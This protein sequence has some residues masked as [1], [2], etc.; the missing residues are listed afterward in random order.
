MVGVLVRT[1]E[2]VYY[3]GRF[4]VSERVRPGPVHPC[5]P[6]SALRGFT[7]RRLYCVIFFSEAGSSSNSA[8]SITIELIIQRHHYV[9]FN[10]RKLRVCMNAC[11][12]TRGWYA[13]TSWPALNTFRNERFPAVLNMPYCTPLTVYD[14]RAFE[15]N[16]ADCANCSWETTDWTPAVLQI[17]SG[18]Q[19]KRNV[20]DCECTA[21]KC[22]NLPASPAQMST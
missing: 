18:G 5:S 20:S 21:E 6:N 22:E 7:L 15:L 11:R 1:G 3:Q 2:G 14:T 13:G 16:S 9:E 8:Y 17:Q 4:G 10:G 12:E 19:T